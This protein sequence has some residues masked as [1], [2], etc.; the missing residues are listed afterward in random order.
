[1]SQLRKITGLLI[2][3][4]SFLIFTGCS[5]NQQKKEDKDAGIRNT[6]MNNELIKEHNDLLN[7]ANQDLAYINT[8]IGELN[9][10]IHTKGGKLTEAQNKA[11]DEF[12]LKRSSVNKRIHEIKDVPQENWEDFKGTFEKDI[13]EVKNKIDSIISVL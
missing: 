3:S 6:E 1:M 2:I 5:T 11:L 10:K 13:S 8:K 12:E 4:F 7:K 9:D